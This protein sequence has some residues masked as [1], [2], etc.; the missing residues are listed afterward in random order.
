MTQSKFEDELN[1]L[2]ETYAPVALSEENISLTMQIFDLA[3]EREAK[4]AAIA[5]I[6]FEIEVLRAER[7]K[8]WRDDLK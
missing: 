2:L 6:D 3:Q 5:R 4:V 1:E 7:A 8:F